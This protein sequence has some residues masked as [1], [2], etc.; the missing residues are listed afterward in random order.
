MLI[1]VF[2]GRIKTA[3]TTLKEKPIRDTYTNPYF[4]PIFITNP[5][6]II[7][8][9]LKST[10]IFQSINLHILCMIII[11]KWIHTDVLLII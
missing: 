10:I 4:I 7:S 6:L 11:Y 3:F 1:R 8:Y 9:I 2:I 5:G